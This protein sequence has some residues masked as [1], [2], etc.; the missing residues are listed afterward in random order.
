MPCSALGQ[1]EPDVYWLKNGIKI[2]HHN[3][4]T[5]DVLQLN[6]LNVKDSAVYTCYA[7]NSK[8]FITKN[9]TVNVQTDHVG[10]ASS[11]I[12]DNNP[13]LLSGEQ[14]YTN[15]NDNYK[16]PDYSIIKDKL[17]PN[18]PKNTTVEEGGSASFECK[19]M[20]VNIFFLNELKL[21][22]PRY[23]YSNLDIVNKSVR[24]FLFTIM[25]NSLLRI[26]NVIW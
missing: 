19:A 20:V 2:D 21:L 24:P 10:A 14:S 4:N 9:F 11:S 16:G 25:N 22:L 13:S 26:S 5:N 23:T 6:N 12:I 18:D 15:S 1:P 3:M 8:G 17:V 7:Q